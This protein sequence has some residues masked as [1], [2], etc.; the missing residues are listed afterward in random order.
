[1]RSH[2]WFFFPLGINYFLS[3]LVNK[4]SQ[5]LTFKNSKNSFV[6]LTLSYYFAANPLWLRYHRHP[7]GRQTVWS[8]L[9]CWGG[10]RNP[11]TGTRG[12]CHSLNLEALRLHPSGS[13]P[14]CWSWL[15][16]V[17][18]AS[19]RAVEYRGVESSPVLGGHVNLVHTPT[20]LSASHCALISQSL[21]GR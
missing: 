15:K 9:P 18:I 2:V 5:R 4:N 6:L 11:R 17:R 1:M 10:A 16:R 12:K 21:Q 13:P 20:L 19:R 3:C 7:A 8:L 14:S